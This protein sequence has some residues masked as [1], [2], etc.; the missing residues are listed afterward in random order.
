MCWIVPYQIV[1][2]IN[3]RHFE[4]NTTTITIIIICN[5]HIKT[6]AT[7]ATHVAVVAADTANAIAIA[8]I[9][10]TVVP[11]LIA[12]ADV[13]VAAMVEQHLQSGVQMHKI[14]THR[15]SSQQFQFLFNC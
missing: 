6:A 13:I 10:V 1:H 12:I 11:I 5:T 3:P 4:A 2:H 15:L 9:P 14:V 7:A 8:T